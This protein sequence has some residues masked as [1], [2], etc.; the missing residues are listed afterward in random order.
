MKLYKLVKCTETSDVYEVAGLDDVIDWFNE[1]Y[2]PDIF[3]KYTVA[4]V[5]D[6]LN[7]MRLKEK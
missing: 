3:I 6:L 5:R 7:T 1:I 2:P 4:Q